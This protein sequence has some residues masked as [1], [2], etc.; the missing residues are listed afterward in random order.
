MPKLTG[1]KP[2][3]IGIDLGTTNSCVGVYDKRKKRIEILPNNFSSRTT[4]S[5]VAFTDKEILVGETAKKQ[6][7][8]N[9][10]NTIFGKTC[11]LREKNVR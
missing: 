3:A 4:P 10:E 5:V 1:E 2:P 11:V 8:R 7:A 9:P 6:A